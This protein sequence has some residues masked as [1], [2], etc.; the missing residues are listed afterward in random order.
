MDGSINIS[1]S[2][3]ILIDEKP[4]KIFMSFPLLTRVTMAIG[5]MDQIPALA[6]SPD[7]QELVTKVLLQKSHFKN[8]KLE[9]IDLETLNISVADGQKLI[10]WAGEHALDFLLKGLEQ[11]AQLAQK[12]QNAMEH[13]TKVVQASS[14]TPSSS[15]TKA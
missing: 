6:V 9:D 15:G 3:E 10:T 1:D 7:M 2:L 4:A 5:S 11:V 14:S 12:N 13:L 8:A